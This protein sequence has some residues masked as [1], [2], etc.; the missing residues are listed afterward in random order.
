MKYMGSKSKIAKDILPIIHKR[1]TDY[2]LN[3]YIE[4]FVGGANIIDKVKCKNLIGLDNNRYLIALYQNLDKLD[5]LPTTISKDHYS[6]VRTSFNAGDGRFDDWYIG[7]V[8]FLA[9]YNGR[10]FD[11]GYS[12]IRITSDGKMRNYYLEAKQNLLKQ[13]YKLKKVNFECKD[14]K[15]LTGLQDFL[16][17]CDPPYKNKKNYGTSKNFNHDEFWYWCRKMSE[18]NI[19]LISEEEAPKDFECI[20]EQ[21]VKRT[22]DNHKSK[23]STEKLF[24]IRE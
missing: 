17:Y 18:K 9:S 3:K 20:W 15:Q 8:G 12:G 7:A 6:A 21:E 14:Y 23:I 22:I 4:P 2:N 1:I 11:G 16:I 24:E 13:S 10:F 5:L 19:V